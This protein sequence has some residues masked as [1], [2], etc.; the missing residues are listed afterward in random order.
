MN[1]MPP[2][3]T[4]AAI[5]E[6]LTSAEPVAGELTR[7]NV[8]TIDELDP[9]RRLP[10]VFCDVDGVLLPMTADPAHTHAGGHND[11]LPAPTFAVYSPTMVDRLAGMN[12]E[13]VWLT[14]WRNEANR[15]LAPLFGWA[16]LPT[17]AR[18]P[19]N[20][21]WKLEALMAWRPDR[22]FV[23]IDDEL[24]DRS[25]EIEFLHYRLDSLDVDYLCVSPDPRCGLSV[26]ELDQIAEFVE[27]HQPADT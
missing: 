27:T 17:V 24:D 7:G 5:D 25:E 23:W 6:E 10:Y 18:R 12:A 21:W 14:S 26:T 4:L 9:A 13:L 22:P 19:E 16:Q 20:V 1:P 8:V 2:T 11:W 15:D 3:F